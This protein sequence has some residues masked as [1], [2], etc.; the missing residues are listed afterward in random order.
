MKY[1]VVAYDNNQKPICGKWVDGEN[2]D[3][4][5]LNFEFFMLCF[6]P[7]IKITDDSLKITNRK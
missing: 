5:I 6:L 3:D 2:D 4:A 1:Y 7:N